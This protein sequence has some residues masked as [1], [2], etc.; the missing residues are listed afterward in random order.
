MV[1]EIEWDSTQKDNPWWDITSGTFPY[2][3]NVGT[4]SNVKPDFSKFIN[5]LSLIVQ[6]F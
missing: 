2:Y 3:P 4:W 1:F 6:T 5:E